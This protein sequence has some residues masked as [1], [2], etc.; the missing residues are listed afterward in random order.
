MKTIQEIMVIQSIISFIAFKPV[1]TS[2]WRTEKIKWEI[3]GS[4]ETTRR[5][6]EWRTLKSKHSVY[7][8]GRLIKVIARK[9]QNWQYRALYTIK[10]SNSESRDNYKKF[11]SSL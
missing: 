5:K 11:T 7:Q 1:I 8:K 9:A 6:K 2:A 3:I 4:G 10:K